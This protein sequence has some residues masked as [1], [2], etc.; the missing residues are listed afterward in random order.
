MNANAALKIIIQYDRNEKE[1][2]Y[3]KNQQSNTTPEDEK[4]KPCSY[5][6]LWKVKKE[7]WQWTHLSKGAKR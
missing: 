6:I 5:P 7:I 2:Q 4:E 3:N 1:E